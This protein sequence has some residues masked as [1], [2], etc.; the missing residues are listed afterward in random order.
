LPLQLN[1]EGFLDPSAAPCRATLEEVRDL[2]VDQAPFKPRRELIFRALHLFTDLVWAVTPDA[3]LWIN[4]GFAT[5]KKWAE[6]E[7]ADVVVIVPI[8]QYK[9]YLEDA[10]LPLS[11][12]QDV[13]AQQPNVHT[14]KL[15]PFGG[16]L[17]TFFIPDLPAQLRAWDDTWSKV[18]GPD[19]KIIAGKRK[20]YLEVTQ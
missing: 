6:P 11:T 2:F 13:S 9:L 8:K 15:H 16:L 3:R 1:T 19:G 12:L 7:D 10:K 4:G 14:Q 5:H 18:K 20:G 17:D